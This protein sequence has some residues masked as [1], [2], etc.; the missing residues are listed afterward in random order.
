MHH[1]CLM[2]YFKTVA[3]RH[4]KVAIE[5]RYSRILMHKVWPFMTMFCSTNLDCKLNKVQTGL[6]RW[7]MVCMGQISGRLS[8]LRRR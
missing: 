8:Q 6:T 2:V 4:G 7:L 5:H 1:T 3:N